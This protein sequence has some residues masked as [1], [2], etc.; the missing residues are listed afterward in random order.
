[1]RL[2]LPPSDFLVRC[3]HALESEVF[4]QKTTRS[5]QRFNFVRLLR[6][7][8][9]LTAAAAIAALFFIKFS[10]D[11]SI[12]SQNA[13]IPIK[14]EQAMKADN[15]EIVEQLVATFDAVAHLPDGAPVRFR[16]SEWFD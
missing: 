9:P 13:V 16:C 10:S 2:A 12:K 14:P 6:W 7:L 5:V 4:H 11:S 15:V 8:A 3:G 1:L